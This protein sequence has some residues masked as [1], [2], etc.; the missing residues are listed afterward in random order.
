M[1]QKVTVRRVEKNSNDSSKSYSPK[2]SALSKVKALVFPL[3][4]GLILDFLDLA[5]FG[6]VGIYAGFLIGFIIG[7]QMCPIFG[8]TSG[9]NRLK[10]AVIAGIY[11]TMPGTEYLPL[12]TITGLILAYRQSTI[13][14]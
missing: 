5:T 14:R 4:S 2:L 13:N 1:A 9:K 11:C 6:P 12:A 8:F 10:W 7:Y 3:A